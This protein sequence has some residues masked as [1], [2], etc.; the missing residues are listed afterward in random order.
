MTVPNTTPHSPRTASRPLVRG[1]FAV[2]VL[3]G[4]VSLVW[5][6]AGVLTHTR[7]AFL[8]D[9]GVFVDAGRAILDHAPLYGDGFPSRSGFAFIYPPLAAVLFVPLTW[10]D[11]TTMQ[12][13]WTW[14]SLAASWAVLTMAVHRVTMLAGASAMCRRLAPLT[15]LA[16]LGYAL[17]L[18]PLQVHLMYGQINVFLVLL[19]AA[20]LLGYTPRWLRGAGVGVA[21]GIKITPA[22]YALVFLVT[23]KWGDLARSLGAFLVTVVIGW[24]FR[25]PDS[26]FFWTEEFFN[27]DRG[28]G[29]GYPP[30]Q[31]L[32]GLL[33]RAGMDPDTAQSVMVP[34]LLVIALI[35]G[36]AVWRLSAAGR[37]LSVLLTLVLAVS[38]SAPIAV[39]HHWTGIIVAL[40]LLA[41]Q[42]VALVTGHR[43]GW[44]RPTLVGTLLLVAANLSFG[45]LSDDGYQSPENHHYQVLPENGPWSFSDIGIVD[46]LY[47]N[48]QGIAGIICLALLCLAAWRAEPAAP[49]EVKESHTS[50]A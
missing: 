3:S 13:V 25:A 6:S 17:L 34:G 8:L 39:T 26:R 48:I 44:D 38:V 28:G 5:Q 22:A 20:D 32:T 49:A 40:V 11:E 15:G 24:C 23:R 2:V 1:L 30:N 35:A 4:F 12:L 45:R 9:V 16:A 37:P 21:A 36:W 27:S 33:T 10:M 46:F 42:V 41:A 29:P 43:D 47:G 50:D 18:E 31:A 19:V 14:A 7:D